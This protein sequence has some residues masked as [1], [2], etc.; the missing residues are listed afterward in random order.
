MWTRLKTLRPAPRRHAP[1]IA[2]AT[3][4]VLAAMAVCASATLAACPPGTAPSTGCP[5]S[6]A[7]HQCCR[8]CAAQHFSNDGKSCKPCPN[9]SYATDPGS[10]FCITC[11]SG[12]VVNAAKNGC[13]VCAAGLVMNAAHTSCAPCPSGKIPN[14]SQIA[15][16]P[17]PSGQHYEYG[18]C[19]P[20][21]QAV[22]NHPAFVPNL[23]DNSN[24]G[25][26]PQGPAATGRPLGGGGGGATTRGPAGIR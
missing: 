20:N 23:L 21:P 13:F 4:L 15:C 12:S 1:R 17:C 25:M 16:V 2:I 24:P 9:G 10:A 5:P 22:P 6:S 11:P 14:A 8:G 19:V 18:G 7:G 3:L 26:G